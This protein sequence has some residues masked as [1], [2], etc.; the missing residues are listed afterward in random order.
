MHW[1]LTAVSLSS[2]MSSAWWQAAQPNCLPACSAPR[3]APVAQ[4]TVAA[5]RRTRPSAERG[6]DGRSTPLSPNPCAS[7]QLWQTTQSTLLAWPLCRR[8]K[9]PLRWSGFTAPGWWQVVQTLTANSG[10]GM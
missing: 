4:A 9:K 6:F 2:G 1:R 3:S 7:L 8:V 5:F 10:T